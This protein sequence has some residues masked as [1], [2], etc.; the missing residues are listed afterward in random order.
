MN[1]K[2]QQYLIEM[3][4]KDLRDRNS[5]IDTINRIVE[6]IE[7]Q[8]GR[9]VSNIHDWHR[10][11]RDF[12]YTN[13]LRCNLWNNETAITEFKQMIDEYEDSRIGIATDSDGLDCTYNID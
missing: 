10:V 4:L 11:D 1:E 3:E 5:K 2:Y 13:Q 7:N 12:D 8:G 9:I 6:F